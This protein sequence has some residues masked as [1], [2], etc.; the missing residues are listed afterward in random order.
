V[1]GPK[2]A[3]LCPGQG[4]QKIGMGKPLAEASPEARAVFDEAASIL[5]E[6]FRRVMWEGPETELKK[7]FN[8]QPA[9]L[10]HSVAAPS[11]LAGARAPISPRATASANTPRTWPRAR[12]RFPLP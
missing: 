4:A 2:L 10:V 7:T 9:L 1:S 8:T 3:L 12:S 6:D 5:G 11:W